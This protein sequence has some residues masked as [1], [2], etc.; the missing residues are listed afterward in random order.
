MALDHAGRL[1][2]V[3]RRAEN[4]LDGASAVEVLTW[5]DKVLDGRW[6]VATSMQDALVVSLAAQVRPG[7]DVV[8]L[9]TGYHF[10]ETL[11]LRDAVAASYPVRL[12]NVQPGLTVEQQD[13]DHGPR[14]YERDPDLCC[15]LRKVTP[16]NTVLELYD[17]WVTGLR[18]AETESRRAAA[19][20]EWDER[21]QI[22]KVNPIVDWTDEDVE[23]YIEDNGIMVNL[24]RGAGYASIGCEPCTRPVAA[25]E[26]ARA[27]RWAGFGKRECGIHLQ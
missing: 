18:K 10:A 22:V 23:S 8:F 4:E 26:D 25:G 1:Q 13:A 6:V 12:L 24:L 2:E 14:L 7:V 5:V 27:G 11:T 3:V 16:L 21:R 9:D 15:F 19:P 17:A 20:V